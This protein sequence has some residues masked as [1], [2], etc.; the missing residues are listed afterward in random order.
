MELNQEAVDSAL[1]LENRLQERVT[2]MVERVVINIVG[3]EIHEALNREKQALL[4]EIIMTV[5][6]SLQVIEREGRKPLWE[7]TPEEFGF[8]PKELS[9]HMIGRNIDE[10]RASPVQ[11]EGEP[12]HQLELDYALQEQSRPQI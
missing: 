2:S 5:G 12:P 4:T 3:K 9:S 8:T 6:K 1:I 7:A 11:S 10:K